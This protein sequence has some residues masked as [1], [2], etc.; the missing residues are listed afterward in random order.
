M[1]DQNY[2]DS[3]ISLAAQ[4]EALLFVAP[5]P[6]TLVQIAAAL[7]KSIVEVER[8][9]TELQS[10]YIQR[11]LRLQ[12]H[13]NGIQLTTAPE[14]AGLIQRFLDLDT[15]TRLSQAALET[16]AI[17]AYKQPVTR[18]EIEAIRGVSCDGVLKSLLSKALVQDIGRADKPGRPILYA[19]TPEFLQAFGLTSLDELP[20]L[21][22]IENKYS[23]IHKDKPDNDTDET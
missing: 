21:E 10:Y 13:G 12:I 11:G 17:V 16:L 6:V 20:P 22:E 18:P 14:V 19:T 5:G 9:L 1:S 2:L 15:S 7:D 4:I 23:N 3:N 8:N